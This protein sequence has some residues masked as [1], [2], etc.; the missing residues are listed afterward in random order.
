MWNSLIAGFVFQHPSVAALRRELLR[1][2]QLRQMC[3]FD[4]F[5]PAGGVPSECAYTRFQ[6]RLFN[7]E[8][9]V[10]EIFHQVLDQVQVLLTDLGQR[11]ALDGKELHSYAKRESSQPQQEGKQ[12]SDGRRDQDADW[13]VKGSG[14][15]KHS[16]FGFLLHLVVDATYELP[17]AFEVTPASA[18]EQPVALR[19]LDQLQQHHGTLLERGEILSADK[20]YDDSKLHKRL[21]DQHQIKPVIDI[22]K[23]WKDGETSKLVSGQQNVIYTYDGQVLCVCPATG[24]QTSMSYGG[25]ERDRDTL[26]YRCPAQ[27][28]GINCQGIDQCPVGKALRIPLDFL[29]CPEVDI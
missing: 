22:R 15:K 14:K 26:K 27:Y 17:V 7:Y 12:D 1:N 19:L 16:W 5:A 11:L 9:Q 24:K 23:L 25:F 28:L 29:R 18:A 6:R 8:Q 13:G 3:G 21:W 2:A 10:M 4:V 20:G